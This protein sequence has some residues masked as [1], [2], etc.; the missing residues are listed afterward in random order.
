[1][2]HDT[3]SS[4]PKKENHEEA[5]TNKSRNMSQNKKN[6]CVLKIGRNNKLMY[7]ANII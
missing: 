3:R 5:N 4:M 6:V 1:M 2:N 7:F